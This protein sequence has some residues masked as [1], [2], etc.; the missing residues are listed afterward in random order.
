MLTEARRY[1]YIWTA[2]KLNLAGAMEFRMS[3][4]LT[5][6][7]MMLNNAVFLFFWNA[8]FQRFQLVNGWSL[9]DIMMLWAVGTAGFGLG[10]MLFGNA[11]RISYLVA[12]GEL[13]TY[14]CQ[15][16][17]VLLNILINRMSLT[18]IGDFLFGLLLY[19]VY[20]D[21]S[22]PGAGKYAAAV[23]L[24]MLFNLFFYVLTQSLAFYIGNAEGIGY[25][26]FI[27][28]ITLSTYPTDIFKGWGK[29]MLF[30]VI[31]AGFISF[32]PVGLLREADGRFLAVTLGAAL[33][34]G[35]AAW[36]VFHRGLRRYSSG[37]RV[38]LRG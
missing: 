15:P 34:F 35:A 8:Y 31:P 12:H 25:Q 26:F 29:I 3:F 19:A 30:T 17:P 5:A 14:L 24:A 33:F 36:T 27:G 37:N 23:L 38:G 7:M 10:N 2:W 20:G 21:H 18:A 22:L 4:F 11:L 9:R 13:D 6:G 16:K 28:F 1:R 32:L